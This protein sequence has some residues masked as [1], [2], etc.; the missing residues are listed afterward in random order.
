VLQVI[1]E[2]GAVEASFSEAADAG[3]AAH[4]SQ[5]LTLVSIHQSFG[6]NCGP[7]GYR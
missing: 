5:G 7:S 4:R 1:V 6:F 2:R 3:K